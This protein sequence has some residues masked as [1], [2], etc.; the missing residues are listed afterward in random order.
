MSEHVIKLILYAVAALI[1]FRL[2]FHYTGHCIVCGKMKFITRE[3][4]RLTFVIEGK[5][6]KTHCCTSCRKKF[7]ITS[8]LLYSLA[9]EKGLIEKRAKE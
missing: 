1:G 8:E 3:E 7:H 2:S 9:E 5:K 6:L 4:N